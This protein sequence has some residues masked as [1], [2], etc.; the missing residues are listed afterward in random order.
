MN[1]PLITT[2]EQNKYIRIAGVSQAIDTEIIFDQIHIE[3]NLPTQEVNNGSTSNV[4]LIL[5]HK[6]Y[7][8]FAY[9][10][11]DEAGTIITQNQSDYRQ[12]FLQVCGQLL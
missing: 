11:E 5:D 3:L 10:Y 1:S 6:S 7:I 9:Y 2:F 12:S 4:T 8:R